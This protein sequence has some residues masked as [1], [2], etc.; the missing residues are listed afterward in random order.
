[1]Q[2]PKIFLGRRHTPR[3]G[4]GTPA[5]YYPSPRR[6]DS[7]PLLKI[8]GSAPA[9]IFFLKIWSPFL[10]IASESDDLFCCRL[11]TT[12][13]FPR[14]VS[15]ILSKF[16][17]KK[18]IL[19]RVSPLEGVTR[20][21][22]PLPLLP[23]DTTV[24][25]WECL[26]F[27]FGMRIDPVPTA[28]LLINDNNIAIPLQYAL[29]IQHLVHTHTIQRWANVT[30]CVLI[31]FFPAMNWFGSGYDP[32]S[33]SFSAENTTLLSANIL[34]RPKADATFDSTFGFGRK[35]NFYFWLTSNSWF[36]NFANSPIFRI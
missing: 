15:S 23:S 25:L 21:G 10:V 28:A 33:V 14:L 20:G 18:L 2:N 5:P 16:N 7:R 29:S 11:L 13:I 31:G 9:P 1:M 3:V 32:L 30:Q 35:W 36:W 27:G 17:H 19:G 12:P 8:S 6:L 4:R 22:P 34:L 26:W 24:W